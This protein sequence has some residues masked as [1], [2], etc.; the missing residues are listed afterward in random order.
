MIGSN[1]SLRIHL[2]KKEQQLEEIMKTQPKPIPTSPQV[3]VLVNSSGVSLTLPLLTTSFF[4]LHWDMQDIWCGG[5]DG[6]LFCLYVV[7]MSN[8]EPSILIKF[9]YIYHLFKIH[10]YKF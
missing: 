5:N 7:Y 2:K 10:L 9:L 4:S 1:Q 3:Q 6:S 8:K